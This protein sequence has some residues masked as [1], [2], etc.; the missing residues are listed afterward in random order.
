MWKRFKLSLTRVT[1]STRNRNGENY[2]PEEAVNSFNERV[3][4]AT[5]KL[6]RE[7][8]E[9]DPANKP[10]KGLAAMGYLV[11]GNLKGHSLGKRKPING[12]NPKLYE[13]DALIKDYESFFKRAISAYNSAGMHRT[14][15]RDGLRI[16]DLIAQRIR[17]EINNPTPHPSAQ[18]VNRSTLMEVN[19]L[20]KVHFHGKGN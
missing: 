20:L 15:S 17:Q 10:P 4:Q 9:V 6:G 18:E 14:N 16:Q 12:P 2:S 19:E 3:A 11:A 13:H 5:R 8:K 1:R 7:I